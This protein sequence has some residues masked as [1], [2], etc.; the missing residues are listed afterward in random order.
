MSSSPALSGRDRLRCM[1]ALVASLAV[2]AITSSLTWPI[3]AE[4]LRLQ[5][6]SENLIGL[7]AAA[8]FAGIMVTALVAPYLISRL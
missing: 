3:L 7:N 4:S 5:G 8:Q 1:V 6:F 2:V